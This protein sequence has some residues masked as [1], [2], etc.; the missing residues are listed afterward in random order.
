MPILFDFQ[1]LRTSLDTSH[2][3]SGMS[4]YP[5]L[6]SLK[7]TF[8]NIL[9]VLVATEDQLVRPTIFL[10]LFSHLED[11]FCSDCF[12]KL[13]FCKTFHGILF[14]YLFFLYMHISII[15]KTQELHSLSHT[16]R[17][18]AVKVVI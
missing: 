3:T 2:N 11:M 16:F 10:K 13:S 17:F 6:K 4:L 8:I 14:I 12:K 7:C 9:F 5:Q 1:T 15:Q 18:L